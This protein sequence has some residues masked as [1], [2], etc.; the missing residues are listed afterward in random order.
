MVIVGADATA[1]EAELRTGLLTCPPCGGVL[2]PWGY[3]RWRNLRREGQEERL[4]PR[5]SRCRSCV[6]TH[7]CLPDCFLLRRRDDAAT[8]GRAIVDHASGIGHRRI[9]KALGR[10]HNTVRRWLA[11]FRDRAELIR[12]HFTRWAHALDADLAPIAS[13][14]SAVADAVEAIG[15]AA[16]AAVQRWG[17]SVGP[18]AGASR[19]TTGALL[20]NTNGALS[21]LPPS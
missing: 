4:R 12:A 11:A 3:G 18:W 8:I 2:G 6:R 7:I 20:H 13:A 14:G 19:L 1:V 17:P 9:A 15:V 5:R 21:P 16:R 10:W